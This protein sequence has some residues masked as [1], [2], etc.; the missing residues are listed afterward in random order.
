MKHRT[1]RKVYISIKLLLPVGFHDNSNLGKKKLASQP[2]VCSHVFTKAKQ[3]RQIYETP[4]LRG[5]PGG[6]NYISHSV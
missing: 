2:T 4:R 1:H 3:I 6:K 5:R